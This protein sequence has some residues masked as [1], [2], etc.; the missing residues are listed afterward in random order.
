MLMLVIILNHLPLTCLS[1]A[2]DN[3]EAFQRGFKWNKREILYK[4]LHREEK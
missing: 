3:S 1:S 4:E 2:I